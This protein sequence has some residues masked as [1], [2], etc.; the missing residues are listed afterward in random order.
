MQKSNKTGEFQQQDRTRIKHKRRNKKMALK[1]APLYSTLLVLFIFITCSFLF[2]RAALCFLFA[3][4][5]LCPGKRNENSWLKLGLHWSEKCE[6]AS[7]VVL[8]VKRAE[9]FSGE[10]LFNAAGIGAFR[11]RKE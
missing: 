2:T 7:T 11:L 9:S 1:I 6:R 10:V 4:G 3:K 8:A 5:A